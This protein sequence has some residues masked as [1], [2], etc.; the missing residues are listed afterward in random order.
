M[1]GMMSL[2]DFVPVPRL[3]SDGELMIRLHLRVKVILGDDL[4]AIWSSR[5]LAY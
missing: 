3:G 5:K 1:C 2:E 4:E